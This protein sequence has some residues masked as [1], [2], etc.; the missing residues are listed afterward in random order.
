MPSHGYTV[1]PVFTS[2]EA[3]EAQVVDFSISE[4]GHGN[5]TDI[6]DFSVEESPGIVSHNFQ[7]LELH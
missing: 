6:N 7:D 2:G 3:G 5:N 4:H 1:S